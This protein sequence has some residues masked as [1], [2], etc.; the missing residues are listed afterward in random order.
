MTAH[1][2]KLLDQ[3]KHSL[4][5]KH[6]SLATEKLYIYWVRF[7]IRWSGLRHPRD[8]A[9]PEVEAFLTTLTMRC[10]LKTL[11]LIIKNPGTSPG[12]S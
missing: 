9:A 7:F 12:F 4:R 11:T 6:Y 5:C 2:P 3:V 1:P 8:M 10:L